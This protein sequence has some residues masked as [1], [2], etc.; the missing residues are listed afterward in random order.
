MDSEYP[1]GEGGKQRNGARRLI[2]EFLDWFQNF[3][4][5]EERGSGAKREEI[6]FQKANVL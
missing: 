1:G 3:P 5:E 6:P 2:I 4:G